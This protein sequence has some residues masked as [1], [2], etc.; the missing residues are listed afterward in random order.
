MA[1]TTR[2]RAARPRSAKKRR[3]IGCIKLWNS[4]EEKATM[5]ARVRQWR[6]EMAK[7]NEFTAAEQAR[8]LPKLTIDQAL[9]QYFGMMFLPE[10]WRHERAFVLCAMRKAADRMIERDGHRKGYPRSDS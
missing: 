6:E 1:T 7:G 3:V 2:A 10:V 5:A 8:D 9:A 4:P